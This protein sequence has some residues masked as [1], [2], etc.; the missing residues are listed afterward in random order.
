MF[1]KLPLFTVMALTLCACASTNQSEA[2]SD[3]NSVERAFE[4]TSRGLGNA[5]MTPVG[6]LNLTREEIPALLQT[7]KDPYDVPTFIPCDDIAARVMALDAVLGRDFDTPK[8]DDDRSL[9][10]K[11]ADGTSS[12][13]LDT[14][15]S[16]AGG[17]IPFRGIVRRVSGARA[18]DRKVLKAYE[19]GSHRRTYLKGLGSSKGC[20]A[21][22]APNPPVSKPDKVIFK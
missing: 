1:Q 15:A 7:I 6:D 11:A 18:W 10:Q 13:L 22:A 9:G 21:P 17:L 4:S 5:A 19:R 2:V 8:P 12:A 16:E 14:V 3:Q 20:S